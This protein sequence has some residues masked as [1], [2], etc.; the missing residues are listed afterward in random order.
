MKTEIHTITKKMVNPKN[1][2]AHCVVVDTYT[3]IQKFRQPEWL[4]DFDCI[5]SNI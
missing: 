1:D 5:E 4:Q 2:S 3:S